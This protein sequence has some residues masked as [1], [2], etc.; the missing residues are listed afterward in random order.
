MLAIATRSSAHQKSCNRL[1]GFLTLV[2][3]WLR[4]CSD[5]YVAARMYEELRHLSNA[6]LSRRGWS[7]A[8][9]AADLL[10]GHERG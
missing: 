10:R 6:E 8:T 4:T 2:R 1:T 5:A 9:L 7:R 3:N